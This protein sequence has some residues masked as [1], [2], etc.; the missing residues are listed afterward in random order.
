VLA[1]LGSV[2]EEE[3]GG[4]GEGDAPARAGVAVFS[5]VG[6]WNGVS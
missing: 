6:V 4:C 5:G 2:V 3:G 1:G